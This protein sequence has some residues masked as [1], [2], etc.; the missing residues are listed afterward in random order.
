LIVTLLLFP[1]LYLTLELPKRIINDAIGAASDQ[2][3][4]FGIALDQVTFLM[5]L[6]M[7][8]LLAVL[9]HGMMKMR[10]NTM[11]GV[12]SE[13]MLRRLRYQLI[14]RLFRFP[15]PFYQRT[16]Q[17]EIVSMVT[18]ESEPLGGMM[19]D[20][21][22]QPIMQAGQMLTILVFLFLQSFW[23]GLAAIAMIP[24]QAWLIPM[25]QRQVNVLNKKR[26]RELRKLAGEI[27]ETA[28]G[29]TTLRTS[30]GYRLKAARSAPALGCCSL[31][32]CR[33]IAKSSS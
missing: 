25:L 31:S 16:S 17:A 26:V 1:P 20:A 23:F 3:N 2:I 32:D 29:S 14:T 22:S 28:A 18:G 10:I 19:G 15:K 21:I 4:F 33:F 12:L 11:K 9:M 6:C 30:G 7:L 27:G 13:R 5:C 8:F 24:F